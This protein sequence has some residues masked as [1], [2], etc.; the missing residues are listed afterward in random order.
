MSPRPWQGKA[1]LQPGRTATRPAR[2]HGGLPTQRAAGWPGNA[3]PRPRLAAEA[4]GLTPRHPDAQGD[5]DSGAGAGGGG[6]GSDLSS[7]LGISNSS[8][9]G[10]GGGGGGQGNQ[11]NEKLRILTDGVSLLLRVSGRVG[12]KVVAL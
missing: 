12:H 1:S 11:L 6:G 8:G 3:S 4:R 10:S 9:G 5:A 2:A 7:I